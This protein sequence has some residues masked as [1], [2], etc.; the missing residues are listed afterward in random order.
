LIPHEYKE[1]HVKK[2][3]IK[4]RERVMAAGLFVAAGIT[5]HN[6]PEG[7]AVL[8]GSLKDIELGITLAFAVAVHNIPEG[9]AVTM[10]IYYA[11][12]DRIKAFKYGF[13]SGIAEPVGAVVGMIV[14]LPFLNEHLLSAALAWVAGIM[15]F[16]S[17]DELLPLSSKKDE[18]QHIAI[19]GLFLGMALMAFSLA[20]LR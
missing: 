7:F 11:T 12:R 6:F 8:V 14:L 18:K 1:E 10:P 13:L 9:I 3:A 20:L 16:I 17:F 2:S 5:I 4:G 15:V 19:S